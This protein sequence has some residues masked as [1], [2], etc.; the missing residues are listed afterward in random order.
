M[1]SIYV[2]N[3]CVNICV[4]ICS[5]TAV[6]VVAIAI[7]L[8]QIIASPLQLLHRQLLHCGLRG[9]EGGGGWVGGRAEGFEFA[10]LGERKTRGEYRFMKLMK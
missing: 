10:R 3:I 6:D 5:L 7:L 8:C 4:N 1:C 2:F 9:G